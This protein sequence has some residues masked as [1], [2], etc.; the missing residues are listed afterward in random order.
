MVSRPTR[1]R[2]A[3]NQ[4]GGS[5]LPLHDSLVLVEDVL[6][7]REAPGQL[8]E[9]LGEG[10]G[11]PSLVRP[12]MAE[13]DYLPDHSPLAWGEVQAEVISPAVVRDWYPPR[14]PPHVLN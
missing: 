8:A 2:A 12:L 9:P 6:A 10:L 5:A 4:D 13:Q 14:T 11:H 3:H 1:L 7:R